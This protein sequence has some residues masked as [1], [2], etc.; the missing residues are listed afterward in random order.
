MIIRKRL[1]TMVSLLLAVTV[2]PARAATS[3]V[4][5]R[6]PVPFD[7]FDSNGDGYID[8]Q[9]FD[10]VR[11]ERLQQRGAEGRMMRN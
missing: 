1:L 8:E 4:P 6:G 10:R 9:E 2:V 7:V 3:E 11:S 5:P